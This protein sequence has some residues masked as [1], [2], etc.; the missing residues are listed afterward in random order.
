MLIG[1]YTISFKK[2]HLLMSSAKWRPC[3]LALSL[4]WRHNGHD[5]VSN[6]QPRHCLLDRLFE[7][8][9]KKTSKL[10]VI[11]LC[12]GNSPG[13]GEFPAQ[14]ASYAGNVFIWWRHHVCVKQ[15]WPRLMT[16]L[17]VT[18]PHNL[19]VI[20][21]LQYKTYATIKNTW[22]PCKRCNI[23]RNIIAFW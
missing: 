19:S 2:M 18:K 21:G 1:I 10:R 11:G 23:I 16:K 8:R 20:S 7:R 3:C 12:V 9:S 4:R 17:V 14:M 5:C 6:H 13:T 22:K 15:W